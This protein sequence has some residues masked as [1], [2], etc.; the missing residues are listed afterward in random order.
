MSASFKQLEM[1]NDCGD[2]M[3]G[4]QARVDGQIFQPMIITS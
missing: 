1:K 3:L 4:V 2:V